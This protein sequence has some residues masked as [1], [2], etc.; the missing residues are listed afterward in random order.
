MRHL[1]SKFNEQRVYINILSTYLSCYGKHFVFSNKTLLFI[2]K[3]KQQNEKGNSG[4]T[5]LNVVYKI[6]NW[7]AWIN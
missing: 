3:P 4:L 5:G 2:L 7:Q 1:A 6:W